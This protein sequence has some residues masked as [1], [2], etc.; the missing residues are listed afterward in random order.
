LAPRRSTKLAQVSIGE[1]RRIAL[2]AQGFNDGTA[3]AKVQPRHLRTLF[4]RIRLI[5]IDSVNVAVRT[6][7]MPAFSRL[8]PYDV[9]LIDRLAYRDRFLFEGWGHMASYVPTADYPLLR[10]RMAEEQ[11]GPA[12]HRLIEAGYVDRV[13]SEV[14]GRGP[15]RVS[16]LEDPGERT[17]SWGWGYSRGKIALE[18][19]FNT[20]RLAVTSRINFERVYDLTERVIPKEKLAG[21]APEAPE[22][23]RE[24]IARAASALGIGTAADLADYYRIGMTQARKAIESLIE[25]GDLTGVRVEGWSEPAYLW[26]D[27]EPARGDLGNA[28]LSPFDSLVWSRPRT[29]R[30]FGFHYRIE[31]YVPAARRK[32]GYYVLPF[33]RGERMAARVDLKANREAKTLEVRN[34]WLEPG[35]DAASVAGELA[36]ELRRMADWLGLERIRVSR[37]GDLAPTLP[38]AV[39]SR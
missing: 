29:E 6:H 23:H 35:Q 9:R 37:R 3:S 1:A 19:L 16:E 25:A 17:A 5:Q 10:H 21:P 8:G 27:P 28:V 20:G 26:R 38:A 2:G 12:V 32:Y 30:L 36:L 18:W 11:P 4:D 31:I 24:M 39:R 33:L 13:Y 7:F 14:A 15:T 22:A 34:A